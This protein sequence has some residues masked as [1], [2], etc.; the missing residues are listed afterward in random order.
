MH[1]SRKKPIVMMGGAGEGAWLVG[2]L[3]H[4]EARVSAGEH[5]DSEGPQGAEADVVHVALPH[6]DDRVATSGRQNQLKALIPLR[7]NHPHLF[8]A[9]GQPLV[10]LV[11]AMLGFV[12]FRFG[13]V[14]PAREKR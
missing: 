9:A 1:A 5:F 6:D 10:G 2:K 3:D 13:I 8:A 4:E 11:Q 12:A 14:R 7:L